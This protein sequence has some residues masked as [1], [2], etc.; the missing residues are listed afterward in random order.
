MKIGTMRRGG[1]RGLAAGVG[2]AVAM[3]GL[4]ACGADDPERDGR[5][6]RTPKTQS[7]PKETSPSATPS[8]TPSGTTSPSG[9]P[10]G[11]VPPP[12]TAPPTQEPKSITVIVKEGK[13]KEAPNRVQVKPGQAVHLE[14]RS[15]VADELHV[16]GVD[17]TLALT[18]G[19]GFAV[20]DF[21][22]PADLAPGSYAVEMHVSGLLLF[23]LEVR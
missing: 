7:T 22:V 18:P 11:T 20:L 6:T 17:K 10:T 21:V 16:H 19:S 8:G 2:V 23:A 15:D 1:V 12:T 3:T 5:P 9:T 14:A 4:V 13:V